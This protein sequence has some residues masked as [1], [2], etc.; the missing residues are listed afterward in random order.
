MFINSVRK[1]NYVVDKQDFVFINKSLFMNTVY[2][3]D[4]VY[5]QALEPAGQINK[6][7]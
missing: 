4:S 7:L 3:H 2:K 1:H 5:K 6:R